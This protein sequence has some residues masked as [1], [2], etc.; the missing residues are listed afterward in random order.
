MWHRHFGLCFDRDGALEREHVPGPGSCDGTW[1][2]GSDLWMLHA[3][4]VPGHANPDGLFVPL[5]VSLCD[6][7]APDIVKC[8]ART[9]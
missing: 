4:V 7:N 9:G 2:N 1:L 6:R 5:L 8:P 3:W